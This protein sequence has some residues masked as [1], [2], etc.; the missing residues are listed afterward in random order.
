MPEDA[1]DEWFA[2]KH[3]PKVDEIG[4]NASA[5]LESARKIRDR[6]S[7]LPPETDE[8]DIQTV[9]YDEAKAAMGTDKASIRKFFS[10]LYALMFKKE[11][12]PRWGQFVAIVGTEEFVK[13][14]EERI[15]GI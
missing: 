3:D 7:K 8:K 9:F 2:P 15:D 5:F 6:I 1:P 4:E 13:M 10:Y 11:S 14:M 12:G